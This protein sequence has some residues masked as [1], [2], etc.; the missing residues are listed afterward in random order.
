MCR[1]N[2]ILQS[3]GHSDVTILTVC[4]AYKAELMDH[5]NNGTSCNN[6]VDRR[7]KLRGPDELCSSCLKKRRID[8]NQGWRAL[9]LNPGQ[10]NAGRPSAQTTQ[11]L[12]PPSGLFD[13]PSQPRF[14]PFGKD[15]LLNSRLQAAQDQWECARTMLS[16]GKLVHSN[17]D[18]AKEIDDAARA[19]MALALEDSKIGH[20]GA[21][22][23]K[24]QEAHD[25][26]FTRK[27]RSGA[28]RGL[29]TQRY[30]LRRR[31]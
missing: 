11:R 31:L 20:G 21:D 22:R 27:G 26:S 7:F 23:T 13:L 12:S 25:E 15:S 9:I 18:E 2:G 16:L 29:R 3:C 8:S 19:L 5:G 24:D 10:K 1:R 6:I 30:D 28:R 14:E 4:P 17:L